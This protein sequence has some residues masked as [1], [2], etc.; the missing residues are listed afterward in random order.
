MSV[1]L[2]LNKKEMNMGRLKKNI[3]IMEQKSANE[4]LQESD[5]KKGKENDN[6]LH[7]E[8]VSEQELLRWRVDAYPYLM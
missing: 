7:L 6:S 8:E 3:G 1:S 2:C 5:A 4:P